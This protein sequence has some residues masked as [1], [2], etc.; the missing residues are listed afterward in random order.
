M[1]LKN[2]KLKHELKKVVSE[3][4]ADIILFGSTVRGKA[5][6]GDIDVLVLFKE[7]IDKEIEY[8][9]R[10]ILEKYSQKISLVSKTRKT[11]LE[12][13]FDA[14]ESVLFE[15][16]SLLTGL[17][18]AQIYGFT[19]FGMFKY[20]FKDW[21][22]LQKTKFYYALNGR[23]GQEGIFQKL[24]CIKLSDQIILVHLNK[25]E[26]FREFL[27]SWKLDYRYIPVVMPERLGKKKILE[28]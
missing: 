22:K 20:N 18:L 28:R 15:G 27:E 26:L 4:L 23:K 2:T 17:N 1:I 6:P 19:S 13:S 16:I 7:K 14:R 10:K 3:E 12:P 25:I 8:K 9:I 24:S 21:T 5:K 11:V